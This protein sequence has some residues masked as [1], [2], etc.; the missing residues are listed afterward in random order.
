[1]IYLLNSAMFNGYVKIEHIVMRETQKLII[2][3]KTLAAMNYCTV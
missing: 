3:W 2:M 1:M